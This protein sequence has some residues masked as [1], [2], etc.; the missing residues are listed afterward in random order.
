MD[1][2][3]PCQ[4]YPLCKI[5]ASDQELIKH[6]YIDA[7]P[8][9]ERRPWGQITEPN[10][11]GLSAYAI[12]TDGVL[13]GLV[14]LWKLCCCLFVE[15]LV[16]MPH[17]RGRGLGAEIVQ[18][19]CHQAQDLPLIL[20]AE[21]HEQGEWASRR[22]DFYARLGLHPLPFDYIQPAYTAE[23]QSIRLHL[24]SSCP[25][26]EHEFKQIRDAIYSTVY[27]YRSHQ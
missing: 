18:W 9:D 21:P 24:L 8:I 17:L 12:Y 7:F 5:P 3:S 22:L 15:H 16:T 25:L 23:S 14:T 10:H 2:H 19:V 27:G 20:E 6:V 26:G 13:A 1:D 11:R 4:F